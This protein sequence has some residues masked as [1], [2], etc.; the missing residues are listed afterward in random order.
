[1]TPQKPLLVPYRIEWE[2]Q[3]VEWMSI[4]RARLGDTAARIE[5]IGSTAIPSMPSK[6]V[7]D[8]QLSVI[9]L[10]SVASILDSSLGEL[11]FQK[12]PFQ[13]DHVPTGSG[14]DPS[15]WSKFLWT[16]QDSTASN[17]NLHVRKV[18]SP[19]ERFS[20]L[21]R[22]WF[23]AH[24]DA[25]PAYGAIKESI[26]MIARDTGTYADVKDPVVDLVN[27]VAEEWAKDVQWKAWAKDL[28]K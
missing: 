3:A 19:N 16:R 22:D 11:G 17:I 4:L 6:D 15:K 24:P 9:D 8:L 14:D 7:I 26:A 28:T 5:H 10:E 1:M 27:V 23:R 21:F 18:G 25:I 13:A 20:L 12:S 2:A